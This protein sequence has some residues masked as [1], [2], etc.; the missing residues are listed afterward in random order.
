[1]AAQTGIYKIKSK[2]NGRLYIGSSENITRRWST[3]LS[4]LSRNVHHSIILQNHVNKY[5]LE[6]LKFVVIEICEVS[7]LIKK[8]QYYLDCLKPYFNV[9]KIADS[10]RGIK[11]SDETK[12]KLRIANLGKKLSKKTKLKMSKRMIGN[13]LTKGITPV[14]ARKVLDT[15]TG[16][17]YKSSTIAAKHKGYK[18]RTLRA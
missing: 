1:M 13:S 9:R 10:N 11:R 17:I 3:H 7:N 18:P 15:E 8:E 5:G 12:E 2:T 14:N 16:I 6:D 4:E